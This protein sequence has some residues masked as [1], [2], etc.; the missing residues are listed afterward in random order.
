MNEPV[1]VLLFTSKNSPYFQ[2][3]I[4]ELRKI[5]EALEHI[6]PFTSQIIDVNENPELAEKYKVDAVPTIIIG[7]K[8][9]IGRPDATDILKI[10]QYNPNL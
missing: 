9:F 5:M 6:Q 3:S 10:V 4:D 8:R 7:D 1:T 2:V